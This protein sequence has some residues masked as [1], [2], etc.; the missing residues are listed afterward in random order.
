VLRIFFSRTV[1]LS[2]DLSIEFGKHVAKEFLIMVAIKAFSAP[3][4]RL[5]SG[6]HNWADAAR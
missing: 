4:D 3:F 6:R 5:L 2:R 1:L